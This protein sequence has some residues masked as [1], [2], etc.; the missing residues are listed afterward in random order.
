MNHYIKYDTI[1]PMRKILPA[2][3][4][5]TIVSASYADTNPFFNGYDNQITFNLG[6]GTNHGFL[7]SPPTQWVPFTMAQI[8]YSQPTTFFRIPARKSL[9]VIQTLGFGKKY[10]WHWDKYTIP[11]AMLS[12]D[13]MLFSNCKWYTFMGIGVGMQAQQNERI[14]SKFLFGFK[15]G[16]GYRI[17]ECTS[18]EAFMQHISN[19]NTAPENNSYAFYGL[20]LSFNF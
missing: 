11:I 18:V 7:L 19:G 5:S 16:A 6:Y 13:I 2:L 20:G 4:L 15:L 10:G 1:F 8:Q 12:E 3:L 14:G 17:S 9:N